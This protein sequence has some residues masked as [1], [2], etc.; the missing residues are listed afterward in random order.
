MDGV[1]GRRTVGVH[2]RRSAGEDQGGRLAGQHLGH[3]H[4]VGHD[5]GVDAG[6][7]HAAGDQLGVLRPEVDD[8]DQVVLRLARCSRH[9]RSLSAPL[10]GSDP[11]RA[12][13][14]GRSGSKAGPWVRRCRSSA[15]SGPRQGREFDSGPDRLNDGSQQGLRPR[16]LDP[17]DRRR[18]PPGRLRRRR[19]SA[20][21]GHPA[22]PRG[23][24]GSS[25]RPARSRSYAVPSA[26]RGSASP[27][28][29]QNAIARSAWAVIVSDG[30]T[31]RLA[32]IVEPSAMCRPGWP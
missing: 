16:G 9:D 1:D 14:P 2:R 13:G 8:E 25:A 6:L 20:A 32:E 23:R 19:R 21:A 17:L 22:R 18:V 7:A 28:F 31:P 30:L 26:G 27:L 29:G 5:L 10:D 4:R 3:R 11:G 15:R 12:P 24:R